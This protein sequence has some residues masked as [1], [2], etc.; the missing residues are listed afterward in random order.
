[1]RNSLERYIVNWT[2]RQILQGV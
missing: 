1:V 2:G